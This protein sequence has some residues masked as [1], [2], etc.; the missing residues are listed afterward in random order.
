MFGLKYLNL[1]VAFLTSLL[2]TWLK[3][4]WLFP[5]LHHGESFSHWENYTIQNGK[6]RTL[7]NEDI[8]KTK[9]HVCVN[10]YPDLTFDYYVIIYCRLH[11]TWIDVGT[12]NTSFLVALDAGSDLFWVPCDCV[13][14]A[15]LS[16]S[17]HSML[18]GSPSPSSDTI[19]FSYFSLYCRKYFLCFG[20]GSS[21]E[22]FCTV[23]LIKLYL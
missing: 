23:F 9:Q 2:T 1:D 21:N 20:V 14:C 8:N 22:N 16:L 13:Q 19:C 5:W 6:A 10:I 17:H 11:Y 4:Q 18:V 3:V 15:S 7:D 12:P